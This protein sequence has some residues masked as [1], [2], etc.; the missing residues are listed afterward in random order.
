MRV[1]TNSCAEPNFLNVDFYAQNAWK[2]NSKVTWTLG[3]R[4]TFN[5]NPANPHAQVARL[6]G[7]FDSISHNVNQPLN[8][9]IQTQLGNLFSSVPLA[10]LQPRTAIAWQVSRNSALRTGFGVFSDLLPGSVADAIGMN[11]PYVQTFQGGLLGTAGGLAIAPGLPNSAVGA[12][13]AANQAFRSGFAQGELSC[14][15][16]QA[17]KAACLQPVAI[18]AVP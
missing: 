2:V 4:D 10:I 3:L 7:S 8:A 9:A 17:N 1:S 5:S 14:A 15:S 13:V 6:S 11:P 12:A 18:T 16:P